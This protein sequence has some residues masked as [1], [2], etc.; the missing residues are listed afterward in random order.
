MEATIT[1][2]K[3]LAASA[4]YPPSSR[5]WPA[6]SS[7]SAQGW[8]DKQQLNLGSSSSAVCVCVCIYMYM[9]AQIF[10]LFFQ[11]LF[12]FFF[13]PS[14][15][16]LTWMERVFCFSFG[17][18]LLRLRGGWG[19]GRDR[20]GGRRGGGGDGKAEPPEIHES[21][22]SFFLFYPPPCAYTHFYHSRGGGG[23]SSRRV[24]RIPPFPSLL[25]LS[26]SP[27]R[28]V[29]REQPEQAEYPR[30]WLL[31]AQESSS[32]IPPPPSHTL[33]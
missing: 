14:P 5:A 2:K 31:M 10:F 12:Y 16:S 7:L 25:P 4:F 15:Y 3:R 6:W 33:F 26:L 29:N 8:R 27:P 1:G 30:G 18:P 17:A 28:P 19:G 21:K 23:S 11:K 22:F 20:E 9:C 32:R 24:P 13:H